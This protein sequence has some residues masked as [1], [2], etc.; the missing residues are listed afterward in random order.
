MEEVQMS[1][2]SMKCDVCKRQFYVMADSV[3][4]QVAAGCPYCGRDIELPHEPVKPEPEEKPVEGTTKR[5]TFG[6]SLRAARRA[7]P[8]EDGPKS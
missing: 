4:G 6:S 1:K 7:R 2:V 5:A 3:K 8:S